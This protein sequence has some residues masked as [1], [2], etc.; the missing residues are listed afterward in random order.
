M[1]EEKLKA[2]LEN[3][4]KQVSLAV[5]RAVD[6][7]NQ[8]LTYCR[9]DDA[10]NAKMDI[11]P[12][13]AVL[14]KVLM[15]L[16]PALPSRIKI[17]TVFESDEIIEIDA[18]DLQQI[19]TNLV[20]NAR[21]AMKEH[22]GIITISLKIVTN[23]TFQCAACASVV[24]GDFIELSVADN[25]TGIESTLIDQ[26]FDPF[27]TTKPQGEGSGLGLSV[28]GGLVAKSGGH[29]LVESNQSKFNHG[30]EFKLLFPMS[31]THLPLV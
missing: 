27:F 6:L 19:V 24:D 17:E 10:P 7:I 26:I 20:V 9:Q 30:T 18:I 5:R 23:V 31:K 4:I 8:M 12:T 11:Q 28:V 1:T 25:G 14:E 29:F 22:G 13:Q 16:R 21:D 3:N 2:E 15:I